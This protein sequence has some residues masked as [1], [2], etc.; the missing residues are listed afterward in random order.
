MRKNLLLTEA[1]VRSLRN[2]VF[3]QD[4]TDN[5]WKTCGP[6][7]MSPDGIAWLQAHDFPVSESVQRKPAIENLR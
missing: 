7:W 1:E 5:E 2:R 4:V 6:H 3:G